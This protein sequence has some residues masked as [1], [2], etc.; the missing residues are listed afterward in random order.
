M[1]EIKKT[2]TRE[3]KSKRMS[4]VKREGK[5]E[6]DRKREKRGRRMEMERKGMSG[7]EIG[8]SGRVKDRIRKV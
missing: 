1:N 7:S 3:G 8:R 6:S 2:R 4:E 5:S